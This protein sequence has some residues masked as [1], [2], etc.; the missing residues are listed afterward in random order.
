MCI[1]KAGSL[2]HVWLFRLQFTYITKQ[3]ALS[4]SF[5]GQYDSVKID[6]AEW[7]LQSTS[8]L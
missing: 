4:S 5:Y 7:L 6:Q 3:R 8:A 2:D 1:T